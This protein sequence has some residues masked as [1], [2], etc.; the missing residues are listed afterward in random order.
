MRLR[1]VA[2]L[3]VVV[4]EEGVRAVRA[5]DGTGWFGVMPGHADFLTSLAISV[6]DW[7][8][9][10]GQRRFCAVRR[11]VFTVRDGVEVAIA[12]RE[13]VAGAD[14]ATLEGEVL[15]R[16]RAQQEAERSE[17]VESTRLQ[18]AA[19]RQI[20]QHLRPERGGAGLT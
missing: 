17:H 1:I 14:L 7:L 16:F 4:E 9:S 10:D 2:P 6:V 8:G 12:T 3:S 15:A 20:M 19:I 13:A 18:L 5:E 11:G